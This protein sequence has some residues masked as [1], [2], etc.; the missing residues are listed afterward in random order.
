MGS[1]DE[2]GDDSSDVAGAISQDH[3]GKDAIDTI[4]TIEDSRSGFYK[5]DQKKADVV[6]R[7]Q[8]VSWFPSEDTI[9]YSAITNGIKKVL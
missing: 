2:Q 8:H 6:R 7:F 1:K 4:D 5:R 9:A 3:L